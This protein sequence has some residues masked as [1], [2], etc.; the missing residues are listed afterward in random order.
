M[1]SLSDLPDGDYYI[2]AEVL[3]YS[4]YSRK[5]LEPVYL[6]KSC[7]SSA[8]MNGEYEKPDG[9]L[10]SSTE[11]LEVHKGRARIT[12]ELSAKQPVA[13]SPG[14]AGLGDGVDSD[15]IK[16]V[17][18][19]SDLLSDFWQQNITLEACVLIPY[20]KQF[21]YPFSAT[22]MSIFGTVS[23]TCLSLFFQLFPSLS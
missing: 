12:L 16:T 5:G 4:L 22:F 17:R 9:T 8:G 21:V 13:S 15:W 1:D 20:G 10:F 3:P 19:R 11:L 14:C 2:Q 7:V 6:P 23:S 18:L